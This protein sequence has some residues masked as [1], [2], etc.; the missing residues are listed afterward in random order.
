MARKNTATAAKP[1]PMI[2][3]RIDFLNWYS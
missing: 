2:T 3:E 1:T